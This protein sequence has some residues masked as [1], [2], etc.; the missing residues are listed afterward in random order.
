MKEEIGMG[1][2]QGTTKTGAGAIEL[3]ERKARAIELRRQGMTYR[4]IGKEMGLSHTA[5]YLYVNELLDTIEAL[6]TDTVNAYRQIQNELIAIGI[7][8]TLEILNTPASSELE[9]MRQMK[10]LQAIDRMNKLLE[11]QSKL[12]GLDMP[13]KIEQTG[14]SVTFVMDM[15]GIDEPNDT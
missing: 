5:I 14:N 15:S 4:A 12:N 7:E 13:T 8:E 10:R 2:P 1:R 3:A 6:Q 9:D 11:R